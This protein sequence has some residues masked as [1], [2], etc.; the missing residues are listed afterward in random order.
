MDINLTVT[1][2]VSRP[3]VRN[4]TG[5]LAPEETFTHSHLWW[6]STILYQ[7]PP[8]TTIHI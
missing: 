8:S 7:L 6:S 4:Y 1:R 2:T 5:E 3:F